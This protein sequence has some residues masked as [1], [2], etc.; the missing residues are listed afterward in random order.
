MKKLLKSILVIMLIVSLALVITGCGNKTSKENET[1][2]DNGKSKTYNALNK[3]FSG[4]S[5]IMS[6][7]GKLDLGEGMENS[8]I[9]VAIKG[10]DIYMDVDATSG[11]LTI[12]Y[13]DNSTYILSHED[14]MY[15]VSEEKDE[16]LFSDDDMFIL[17]K[18][19]LKEIETAEYKTG[20]E[21]I[22]GTEYEYEEYKA[23]GNEKTDRYYFAGNDLKY[24]KTTNE[25]GE[26]EI[27]KVIKLSSEV[28]D[29]IFDIPTDYEKLDI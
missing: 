14:K 8:K 24:I 20:K 10:E 7:E 23:D 4:D 17:S 26:E 18:E 13:K 21:T 15:M 11:H 9:T 5:Y 25:N 6:L 16:D 22:D 3:A 1:V 12:M 2:E 29:S 27:I 28:D 19:D